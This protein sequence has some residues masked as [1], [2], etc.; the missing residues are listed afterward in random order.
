MMLIIV[1][2]PIVELAQISIECLITLL[3]MYIKGSKKS[4]FPLIMCKDIFK[5]TILKLDLSISFN[6]FFLVTKFLLF[7]IFFSLITN[8]KNFTYAIALFSLF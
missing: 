7:L 8:N 3:K 2:V 6:R 4:I 5:K 1:I